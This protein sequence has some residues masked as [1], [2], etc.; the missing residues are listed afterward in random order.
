AGSGSDARASKRSGICALSIDHSLPRL[1]ARPARDR[2]AQAREGE[3]ADRRGQPYR[4]GAVA[5]RGADGEVALDAEGEEDTDHPAADG[6][7][8]REG[9]A[10][11]ADEVGEGDDGDGVGGAERAE[12]G[13]EHGGVERPPGEGAEQA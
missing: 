13:P 9:V 11:L 10:D 1:L 8:D 7:G 3:E 6:A 12:H 5:Q 2:A 4:D